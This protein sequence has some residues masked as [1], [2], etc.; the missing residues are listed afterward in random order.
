MISLL[1]AA[2]RGSY[3]LKAISYGGLNG[4]T[5]C[6]LQAGQTFHEG[7]IMWWLEGTHMLQSFKQGRQSKNLVSPCAQ[8]ACNVGDEGG[9]APN[10]GSNEEG[11]NLVNQAIEVRPLRSSSCPCSVLHRWSLYI[12]AYISA[13][14]GG[15]CAYLRRKSA[16]GPQEQWPNFVCQSRIRAL[17]G[18][19]IA[20]NC[21][22]LLS[23][24]HT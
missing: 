22:A 11:L 7:Y 8:D 13:F 2:L 18:I 6:S 10:I 21:A 17:C 3:A 23:N 1:G 24:T 20:P 14:M 15:A 5:C 19:V 16:G 4:H 12:A 9:F